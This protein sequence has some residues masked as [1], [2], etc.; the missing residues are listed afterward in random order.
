M[1]DYLKARSFDANI[2]I[3]DYRFL[4]SVVQV[5]FDLTLYKKAK[6][7]FHPDLYCR[8]YDKMCKRSRQ[9]LNSAHVN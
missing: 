2:S 3:I 8:Y 6:E 5:K 7:L 1:V 4:C 9:H